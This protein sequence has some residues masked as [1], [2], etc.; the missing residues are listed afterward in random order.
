[1]LRELDLQWFGLYDYN[2]SNVRKC[3]TNRSGNYMIS[4]GLKKG[5][6][7]P[8]YVGKTKDLEARLLDH[9]AD[10]EPNG[11]LKGKVA[12][13]ALYFR[14]CYVPLEEDRQNTEHSMYKKY[15]PDCNQSEPEGREIP[16]TFP[17]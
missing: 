8:I 6:Y 7:R 4:V 15:M 3:A 1:M 13:N 17:Y 14:V 11:C 10:Y 5:G 2:E 16:I 9:L 12:K